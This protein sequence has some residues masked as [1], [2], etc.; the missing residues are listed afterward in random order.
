M[1]PGA[2]VQLMYEQLWSL[3]GENW[4][5][6]GDHFGLKL[7]GTEPAEKSGIWSGGRIRYAGGGGEILRITSKEAN[8]RRPMKQCPGGKGNRRR[9]GQYVSGD[10]TATKQWWKAALKG[11]IGGG[12]SCTGGL[13]PPLII[14]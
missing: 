1:L 12:E 2:R 9:L 8:R 7:C 6:S 14:C 3:V 5:R 10:T 13:R 11:L 4:W